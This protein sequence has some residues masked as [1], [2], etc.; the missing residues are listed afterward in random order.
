[1][2]AMA[3]TLPLR[4][5][6]APPPATFAAADIFSWEQSLASRASI[7]SDFEYVQIGSGTAL[8]SVDVGPFLLQGSDG[9]VEWYYFNTTVGAYVPF[10]ATSAQQNGFTASSG[11]TQNFTANN[12][13][14]TTTN[15]TYVTVNLPPGMYD[16]GTNSAQVLSTYSGRWRFA[17]Q[18]AL[19]KGTAVSTAAC[20]A[21]CQ[22]VAGATVLARSSIYLPASATGAKVVL[23]VETPLV[24]MAVGQTVTAQVR[25]DNSS[26]PWAIDFDDTQCFFSG[27]RVS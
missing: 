25:V 24:N 13:W 14:V 9:S 11:S 6:F 15:L 1:M 17:L 18:L 3:N 10:P 22:I 2:T 26:D 4:L 23:S 7:V 27:Y 5:I 21:Q 20:T 8:P 19:T 16:S 12:A